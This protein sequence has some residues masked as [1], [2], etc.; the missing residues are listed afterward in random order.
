[1]ETNKILEAVRKA[2]SSSKQ[3]K[4]N[5]SID[6]AVSLRDVNLKDPAKRFRAEVLLPH[7]L[8]K[9]IN[10]CVIGDA[11]LLTKAQEAGIKF[12]L[13]ESQID[14]LARNPKEAKSFIEEIDYF[15][16]LPQMMALVGKSLGRYLGPAGKMPSILPPNTNLD[17]SVTRYNRT[18]RIRLRENPVLHCRVA[19]EDM[20][21]DEI[22]D[23]VKSIMTEIEGRL[24]Q[25]PQNIKKTHIK[26]TMG[27]PIL[28]GE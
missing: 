26:T 2:K 12:T 10:I 28:I 23:N 27:P 20:T 7:A 8:N 3:R 22:V 17:D 14:Q 4:F 21:D 11:A 25:G 5:Q 1:M 16:A 13:D 18:C 24:E 19:T 9:E 6:L 15:L